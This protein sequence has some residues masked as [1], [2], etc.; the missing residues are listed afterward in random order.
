MVVAAV[1]SMRPRQWFKQVFVF[2]A[3]LFSERFTDPRDVMLT[4][5]AFAVLCLLSSSGYLFNDILDVEADRAHPTKRNRPIASGTLSISAAWGLMALLLVCGLGASW[6]L[7]PA[8]LLT[9]IGYLAVTLSYSLWIKHIVLLD[10]MFLAGGFILRAV[11]GAEAIDVP[12]S[13]WFLITTL[14]LALFLGFAKRS[15]ELRLMEGDATK[16]RKILAEYSAELLGQLITVCATGAI[17]SYAMYTFEAARTRYLMVT[18]PMV[19]YG[20]FR[21]FYLIHRRS[22]GGAPELTLIRDPAMWITGLL[23]AATVVAVLVLIPGEATG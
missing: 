12:I 10:A 6:F 18:V 5:A 17:L 16:S 13:A 15:A 22:G 9:A 20:V 7:G 11:A 8:F 14:F 1:R 23:Y 2:P 19:V 3:L 4:L 21:Y